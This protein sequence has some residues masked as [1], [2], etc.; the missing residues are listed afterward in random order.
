SG[1]ADYNIALA[2]DPTDGNIV[3]Y[4]TSA[5]STNTSGT[6]FRSKNGGQSWSDLSLGDGTDG[7]HADT[8]AIVVSPANRNVL[9]TG[10][11]GG[12]WRTNNATDNTVT[13]KSLNPNLNITQFQSI[14]L[15][16]TNPNFVIG[17]TQDNGT[18]LFTGRSSWS[19]IRGGDGGFTLI[20]QSNP[21]VLYH[22]F[23]NANNADN[24]GRA[25]IGPEVS[26]NGG[27]SW[28]RR[29]CFGCSAVQGS[30]NPT[31]RVGFYAPMALHT[32][33]TGQ[34]GNVIYLGT[35]RLYRSENRGTAWV[36][37]GPSSDGFGADLTRGSSGR[38]SAIVAHPN[39]NGGAE[40]VWAG[41]TD[42]SV[43]VTVNASAG[44]SATFINV[45]KAPLPNRFVSDIAL[46][47]NNVQHAI[48][49]FS[50]FNSV[51]PATPGHIFLTT[52]QG[53]SWTD[54]SGNLPDVPVA[55]AAMNPADPNTI[56]I[57][58]DLGVF[59]TTNGGATWER[60]GNGMP[61][62][63]TFM[64]RYQAAT[65]TLFAATHGRG[66]YR[67]TT[68]RGVSTV[69]AASF[70]A[71]AIASEAIV[72]AFGTGLAT[73]TEINNTLP[74]PTTLAGTRV[75][76]RDATGVERLS[77]L[78]FV[79]STQVNF[80]IPPGTAAG[81]ATITIT[82]DDGTVSIGTV[83]VATVAPSLF[84]ANATGRDVA[85]GYALRVTPAGA[86]SNE[87][88]NR[89]DAGLNKYIPVSVDLN[90]AGNQ[91]FLVLFG[92]GIR[93]RSA[94]SGVTATIGG[95][96]VPVQYAGPQGTFVGL[97]QLNIGLPASLTGRGEVDLVLTV[98]GKP[99]N[100][101]RVNIK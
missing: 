25:Q 67:L 37:L 56:Y 10:S 5:N 29:G 33:F 85:A 32:G 65:N 2:I 77:P 6:V 70:N 88:I 93:F 15:H 8:H 12:I 90:V 50:G 14:A 96:P 78:F 80:L 75:V 34:N 30:I 55:S 39:R 43:Q 74:L 3:Y 59:Q 49:T 42:G 94:L 101:V 44:A 98:D 31:D 45:T 82:A 92:T 95:V 47:A 72:A 52:N 87:P 79:A 27:S 20:D 46:D 17:G 76:V 23:F 68:S 97:D 16:P 57:G 73:R 53:Q 48:V 35:H 28:S 41:A 61:R 64:V 9:F 84:T 81:S 18:N 54:I 60:M 26:L 4:G 13:W 40:I 1:Q 19:N 36:G 24:D 62:V 7:L 63:A 89:F 58:T 99:S 71:S 21:Q 83:Q 51:T 11:D 91:V 86:Q 100:T 69:S 66:V 38:L 22:T